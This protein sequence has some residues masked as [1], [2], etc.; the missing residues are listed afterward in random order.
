MRPIRKILS[1]LI[2]LALFIC[3]NGC[4]DTTT[5]E[6]FI[7]VTDVGIVNVDPQFASND[8][9]LHIVYNAFEGLMKYNKA[10]TLTCGAAET[11]KVSRDGKT[12]TFNLKQNAKWSDGRPLTAKDFEF[13]F[14]RAVCPDTRS[15]YAK[16]LSPIK[17]VSKILANE[18]SHYSIAVIALDPYTL[19]IKLENK[20][21]GFLELLTTPVA[22]PCN[23]EFFE[24]TKGYYGLKKDCIISNGYYRLSSWNSEYCT[25][26]A[27]ED[28]EF[29]NPSGINVAYI[30]FKKTD[31]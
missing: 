31:N 26:K 22:M 11:Y 3:M 13:A 24:S 15:P 6:P 7:Y 5:K 16:T 9:E 30:Y 17:N 20:T 14:K 27:N 29:Y 12:Y 25:L 18:K 21:S 2:A 4:G 10:G 1:L 19:E 28:Y 23:E 8:T